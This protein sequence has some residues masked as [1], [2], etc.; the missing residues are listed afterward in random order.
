MK[1]S[2]LIASTL[3]TGCMAALMVTGCSQKQDAAQPVASAAAPPPA[4]AAPATGQNATAGAAP[5]ITP[6]VIGQARANDAGQEAA[7]RAKAMAGSH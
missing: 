7:A 1:K 4:Q 5:Q 2:V 6:A 3:V